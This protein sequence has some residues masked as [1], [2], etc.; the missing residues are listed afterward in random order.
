VTTTHAL[1]FSG[2]DAVLAVYGNSTEYVTNLGSFSNLV[3][4]GTNL[5]LSSIMS[6]VGGTNA[7]KYTLFGYNGSTIFFGDSAPIGS[8]TT[9]QKNQVLPA[10]LIN[11]LINYSGQLGAAGDARS[12]FPA[13]DA[14]SFS[15]NLNAA[16]TDTLGGSISSSHPAVANIDT[17]LNLLQRPGAANTLDQVGTAFLSSQNGHFVV[18]AVPVPAAVVLFATGVIGLVGLARRRMSGPQ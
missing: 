1:Q 8:W 14:L 12:L 6:S 9:I 5:D 2:G 4:T 15:T 11:A 3:S 16:G 10:T 18:S 7:I 17:V 13:N